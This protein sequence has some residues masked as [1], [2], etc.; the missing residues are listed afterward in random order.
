MNEDKIRK[1]LEIYL[2]DNNKNLKNAIEIIKEK[3]EKG[4][5]TGRFEVPQQKV[6]NIYF[7]TNKALYVKLKI[8]IIKAI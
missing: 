2:R 5:L 1:Q 7:I 8:R 4:L 3:Y 6:L